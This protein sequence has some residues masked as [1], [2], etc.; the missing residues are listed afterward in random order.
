MTIQGLRSIA[1]GL[2]VN[3]TAL[4][5]D[6]NVVLNVEENDET[7]TEVDLLV[8]GNPIGCQSVTPNR[9]PGEGVRLSQG[10]SDTVECFFNTD[11][12]QGACVGVQLAPSFPNG[13][14]TLGARITTSGGT[15]DATNAAAI[16]LVNGN[17]IIVTPHDFGDA[18]GQGI[19]GTNGRRYWGGPADLNGDGT[20][21]NTVGFAA[22]PV[23]YN[24]VNVASLGIGGVATDGSGN[25]VNLGSGAGAVRQD[26]SAP[27]IFTASPTATG[28]PAVE[29]DPFLG[30]GH[31][32]AQ[33]GNVGSVFDSNGLNVT[34][35]FT[36]GGFTNF[37]L[38][39]ASPVVNSGGASMIQISAADIAANT[40]YSAGNF[41]ISFVVDGGVGWAFGSGAQLDVEECLTNPTTPQHPDSKAVADIDE[42]DAVVGNPVPA[43]TDNAFD[44]WE[45]EVRKL[46]DLLGNA[47][48]LTAT[49]IPTSPNFGKDVGAAAISMMQP[50]ASVTVLNP[51]ANANGGVCAD[52]GDCSLMFN[53]ADVLLANGDP[54]SATNETGCLAGGPCAAVVAVKTSGPSAAAT[55]FPVDNVNTNS[56]DKMVGGNADFII[57]FG[58]GIGA[59]PD[60]AYVVTLTVPDNAVPANTATHAYSF[61]LDDTAPVHGALNPAPVGS[62]GT[63][64][65][66]IVFTIGGSIGD[67]NIIKTATLTVIESVD[68]NCS[69]TGDN[70]TLTV[71][72]GRID[73]NNVALAN[74]TNAITFNQSFTV[75][76]P[77]TG[78]IT[79]TYCF[80]ITAEDEAKLKDGTATGNASTLNTQ[81]DVTWN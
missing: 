2:P 40:S 52:L 25:H 79:R 31:S 19:I 46:T 80:R 11:D 48:N 24:N 38:D 54:G 41:G 28:N 9:V 63:N 35:Q 39:F 15:R 3:P 37:W 30:T 27:F 57:D 5:G 12:V 78:T 7:V 6:I 50:G 61:T 17:F 81:V 22:C 49:P 60:G 45:A 72:S 42:E 66:S 32:I 8:N 44:C 59:Q 34:S 20:N 73:Q 65:T 77:G 18:N 69:T 51:D 58:F 64:A 67:A 55:S 56:T 33:F 36:Y 43:T 74:G 47:T 68:N 62:P 53:A 21:D 4:A 14:H 23:A 76:E 29:D 16:T 71:A 26:G 1:T 13:N 10:G 75:T 70:T